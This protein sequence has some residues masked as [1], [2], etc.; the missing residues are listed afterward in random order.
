MTSDRLSLR[1]LGWSPFFQADLDP[2]ETALP[3]RVAAVHR[4]AIDAA[5]PD[6]SRRLGL[7]P[8][9]PAATLAVGDWLLVAGDRPVRRLE[10][11]SLLA[12]RAAGTGAERQLIAANLDTLFIVTSCNADFN[13][14]RLERY[15]ALARQAGVMPVLVLTKA[16]ACADPDLYRDRARRLSAALPVETINALDPASVARL[17]PWCGPGQTVALVGMSGVGKSTLTNTLTG[18]GLATQAVRADDDRGRHTTTARSLH[19]TRAGGWLIDTPGMRA[20]RLADAAE[21]LAAVFEDVA[22]LAEGCRFADCRHEAEPGCAVQAAIAEA[23][24]DPARLARWRKLVREEAHNSATLAESRRA[25]KSFGRM[26]RRVMEE[27]RA[28]RDD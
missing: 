6:G 10:R 21:G 15:L 24:L 19:R 3:A 7:P 23:R 4:A 18:A 14:A 27:K 9:L 20:L 1:D 5:T 28:R 16:D 17:E 8:T 25:E 11:K 22:S 13:P 12:R 26:V 2:S